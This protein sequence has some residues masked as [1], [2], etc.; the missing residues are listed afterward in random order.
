M[1]ENSL[2]RFRAA[3]YQPS[4]RDEW[5]RFIPASAN[6]GVLHS[7]R[8]LD[9]HGD[10][11]RDLSLVFRDA[12]TRRIAGLLP[13]AA[14]PAGAPSAISHPGSSFGGLIVERP[15]PVITAAMFALASSLLRA[16]G[17]ETLIYLTHPTLF[18]R[19]PDDTDEL[20]L[21]LAGRAVEFHLW[22]VI[23]LHNRLMI[24]KKRKHAVRTAEKQ[25]IIIRPAEEATDYRAFYDLLLGNLADR[26]GRKPIHRFDE[27]MDLRTRLG[28]SARL[29]A[30]F[31]PDGEMVAATWLWDY[32][33]GAWHSQYLCASE[34][35][36]NKDAV[37]AL[38]SVCSRMA[39]EARQNIYSIGRSSGADGW[40]VNESLLKFKKRLGCGLCAQ[41]KF[42]APL[43]ELEK[44]SRDWLARHE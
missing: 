24:G 41:K 36:R 14:A 21:T 26:H 16:G 27:V 28:A 9:H 22:S 18:H 32:E 5:D 15:D 7:R 17:F 2:A 25:G 6:G 42:L 12:R 35:G 4:D 1:T 10:R 3:F 13:L 38:V 31:A 39:A 40:S 44:A 37:D 23:N 19:Q 20:F 11:F 8:F 34:Q 30:A 29:I 43:T 33:N